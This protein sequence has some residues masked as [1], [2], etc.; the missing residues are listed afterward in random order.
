MRSTN[1]DSAS[2]LLFMPVKMRLYKDRLTVKRICGQTDA[3]FQ[4]G[5]G[6]N[7]FRQIEIRR[8]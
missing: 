1:P 6:R 8:F 2:S 4:N 3:L 5:S 7:R